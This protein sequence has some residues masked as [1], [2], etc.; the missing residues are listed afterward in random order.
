M[1][2]YDYHSMQIIQ[3]TAVVLPIVVIFLVMLNILLFKKLWRLEKTV[4]R[5]LWIL[6]TL[7]DIEKQET[8]LFP[9]PFIDPTEYEKMSEEERRE[10]TKKMIKQHQLFFTGQQLK[11]PDTKI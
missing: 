10:L 11:G 7:G 4:M 2:P 9:I 8:V 1:T 6:E 3:F 5:S